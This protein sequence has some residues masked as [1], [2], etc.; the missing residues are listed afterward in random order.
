MPG[1]ADYFPSVTVAEKELSPA[2]T[3]GCPNGV[4]GTKFLAQ[5]RAWWMLIPTKP[6]VLDQFCSEGVLR[7]I[8]KTVC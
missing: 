4:L 6:S 3:S 8:W 5:A 7:G 1:L 2:R